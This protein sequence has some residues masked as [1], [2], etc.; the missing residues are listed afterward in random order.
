MHKT[1]WHRSPLAASWPY[2]M[3]LGC[4]TCQSLSPSLAHPSLRWVTRRLSSSDLAMATDR[5][6]RMKAKGRRRL[7]RSTLIPRTKVIWYREY[8]TCFCDAYFH[9]FGVY[10]NHNSLLFHHDEQEYRQFKVFCDSLL[11]RSSKLS[12]IIA[13]LES[14][15]G[16]LGKDE[17]APESKRVTKPL[18]LESI[19]P[20]CFVL[21]LYMLCCEEISI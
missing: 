3:F 7:S 21:F 5:K 8:I 12:D 18:I 13:S 2:T 1:S 10:C 19:S 16:E 20:E 4:L 15:L 6:Q 14:T 11:T 9:L 17:S